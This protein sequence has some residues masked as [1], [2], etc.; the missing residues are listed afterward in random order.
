MYG[1]EFKVGGARLQ[2]HLHPGMN[3]WPDP[4]ALFLR[5]LAAPLVEGK[6]VDTIKIR[7]KFHI[8]EIDFRGHVSV[9]DTVA[10]W[11]G[12]FGPDNV[13]DLKSALAAFDADRLTTEVI[14]DILE[15]GAPGSTVFRWPL[16]DFE[17]LKASYTANPCRAGFH[18]RL[19]RRFEISDTQYG[20]LVF[21]ADIHPNID[22]T[23]NFYVSF[24]LDRADAK[25]SELD[26]RYR[27]IIEELAFDQTSGSLTGGRS[28]WSRGLG[29]A[30][31]PTDCKTLCMHRGTLTVQL[32]LSITS[33]TLN[34]HKE[35][36]VWSDFLSSEFRYLL[37]SAAG[38]LV[39]GTPEGVD[40][41]RPHDGFTG[42]S[43]QNI[44]RLY[45]FLEE[46]GVP[47]EN[48]IVADY[49]GSEELPHPRELLENFVKEAKGA[50]KLVIYFSGH[51]GDDGAWCFRW[52]PRGQ[53][54]GAD[55]H[56]SP[57]ELFQWKAA[58]EPCTERTPLEVIVEAVNAGAWCLAA[59]E[60]H[61]HGRVL[62]ACA[63]GCRAW[64]HND[65]SFFTEW[66]LGRG[67]ATRALKST[68]LPGGPQVPWEYTRVGTA[69]P[70]R[71]RSDMAKPGTKPFALTGST[72]LPSPSSTAGST[73]FSKSWGSMNNM[74]G[75][76]GFS[77]PHT[78]SGSVLSTPRTQLPLVSH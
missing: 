48:L 63:P 10:R 59:K 72:G 78:Q 30:G 68:H 20:T 49:S 31:Q 13:E 9:K 60:A 2:L 21:R 56:V 55:V 34:E 61:L 14:V 77:R 64:A 74:I 58:L 44:H 23:G 1:P 52:R 29:L 39:C 36:P 33:C 12:G 62:A 16:P 5:L 24:K 17:E 69:G 67:L 40:S 75:A 54:Y 71:I 65:I 7:A 66:L 19:S 8:R 4:G 47:P 22:F 3:S 46:S 57:S 43:L 51:A 41:D 26:L 45:T 11:S 25:V 6:L 70:L 53:K 35:P 32:Q 50:A 18:N 38:N 37:L 28:Q 27:V 73:A 42:V 76:A 15:L